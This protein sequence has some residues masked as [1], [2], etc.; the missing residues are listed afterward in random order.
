MK[1]ML[2]DATTSSITLKSIMLNIKDRK[3]LVASLTNNNDDNDDEDNSNYNH[4]LQYNN[5]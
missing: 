2:E 5:N 1:T 3:K 4:H